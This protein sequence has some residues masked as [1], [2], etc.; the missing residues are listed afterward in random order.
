MYRYDRKRDVMV[1]VDLAKPHM[2]PEVTKYHKVGGVDRGVPRAQVKP[3]DIAGKCHRIAGGY[4]QLK[5][6]R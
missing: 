3:H 1:K 2:I 4:V 6:G 5:Y